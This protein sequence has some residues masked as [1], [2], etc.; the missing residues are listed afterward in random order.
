[1]F[2]ETVFSKVT[3][4]HPDRHEVEWVLRITEFKMIVFDHL[5]QRDQL[6]AFWNVTAMDILGNSLQS[7]T[8]KVEMECAVAN[9]LA[10][11]TAHDGKKG[12]ARFLLNRWWIFHLWLEIKVIKFNR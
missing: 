5:L 1:M 12:L 4:R 6:G 9:E 11:F 2:E 3:A 8:D 7:R 10:H